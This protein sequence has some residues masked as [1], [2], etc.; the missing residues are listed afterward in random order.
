MYSNLFGKLNLRQIQS[1]T[2][3]SEH[4]RVHVVKCS[5]WLTSCQARS[6]PYGDR[7][8]ADNVTEKQAL[9]RDPVTTRPPPFARGTATRDARCPPVL[10]L[11]GDQ[12]IFWG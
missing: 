9:C 6:R 3:A 11:T 8:C 7:T 10:P 1:A 5:P 12:A 2:N 4:L